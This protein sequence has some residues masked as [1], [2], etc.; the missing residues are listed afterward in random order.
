MKYA[1][2]CNGCAEL[3]GEHWEVKPAS[4]PVGLNGKKIDGKSCEQCHHHDKK[5]TKYYMIGEKK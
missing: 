4:V 5:W 2:L 3:I 1:W